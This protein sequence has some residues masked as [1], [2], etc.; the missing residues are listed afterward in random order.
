MKTKYGKTK[1]NTK[2]IQKKIR[3]MVKK[4]KKGGWD[5]PT[6]LFKNYRIRKRLA[7]NLQKQE[8]QSVKKAL[9]QKSVLSLGEELRTLQNSAS[10]LSHS[11]ILSS[12][13]QHQTRTQAEKSLAAAKAELA[14]AESSF[15]NSSRISQ[16]SLTS[17]RSLQEEKKAAAAEALKRAKQ[18]FTTNTKTGKKV[19]EKAEKAHAKAI[20]EAHEEAEKAIQEAQKKATSDAIQRRFKAEQE[21]KKHQTGFAKA[22]ENYNKT[23]LMIREELDAAK[24]KVAEKMAKHKQ[25]LA[26]I[27]STSPELFKDEAKLLSPTPSPTIVKGQGAV[28]TKSV[29]SEIKDNSKP[30]VFRLGKLEEK[31]P[32]IKP[33]TVQGRSLTPANISGPLSKKEAEEVQ[34]AVRV[35]QF[36]KQR[37]EHLANQGY[38]KRLAEFRERRSATLRETA[39]RRPKAPAPVYVPTAA[40]P[41]TSSITYAQPSTQSSFKTDY[42]NSGFLQLKKSP[43]NQHQIP[44]IHRPPL[45]LHPPPPPPPPPVD[46]S[47]GS[48]ALTEIHGPPTLRQRQQ[49][50]QAVIRPTATHPPPGR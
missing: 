44:Q 21:L 34:R 12:T 10:P 25:E 48:R 26:K 23:S 18:G 19:I 13:T 37:Q 22:S 27:R 1:K 33:S 50:A 4:T 24:V 35:G 9:H 39:N 16:T 15:L 8:A 6:T 11:R 30:F 43:L 29:V 45:P 42:V 32:L 38:Q 17:I 20:Q 46:L 40:Q 47:L 2:K 14:K 49:Q 3:S 5:W 31:G 7:S 36:A 41:T 28:P